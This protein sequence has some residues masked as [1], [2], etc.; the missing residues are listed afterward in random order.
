MALERLSDRLPALS[1]PDPCPFVIGLVTIRL[2]SELK[3]A[4]DTGPACALN[5]SPIGLPLSESQIPAM[6]SSDAMKIRLPSE[7]KEALDT[8][9]A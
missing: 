9:P 7:L 2:P 4:L 6:L 8:G 1:V 5:G 3:E